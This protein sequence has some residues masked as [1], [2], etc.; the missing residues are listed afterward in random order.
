MKNGKINKVYVAG[1]YSADN[2]IQ[3]LKN[4]REGIKMSAKLLKLGYS[5]FCP[6]LDHQFLFYEDITIEQMYKYSIDFLEVCD[7][8]YV[9]PNSEQSKGTQKEIL[10]ANK[11][12]IPVVYSIKELMTRKTKV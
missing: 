9:L 10:I 4:I 2:V 6:F 1:S 3:V 5:P 8:M 12:K 7:V 11:L